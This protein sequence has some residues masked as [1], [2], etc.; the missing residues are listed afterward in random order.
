MEDSSQQV[1]V[2]DVGRSF[3]VIGDEM[4]DFYSNLI[5]TQIRD[6]SPFRIHGH[7]RR[8]LELCIYFIN[9]ILLEI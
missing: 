5:H 2:E 8:V 1:S 3:R 4:N 7:V 6:Q 9:A